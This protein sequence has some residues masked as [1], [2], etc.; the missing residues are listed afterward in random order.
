MK[1]DW[2]ARALAIGGL[3]VAFLGL[4]IAY[5]NY[6]RD[7][8]RLRLT[9]DYG[10]TRETARLFQVFVSNVGYRPMSIMRVGLSTLP[11]RKSERRLRQT[12][13]LIHHKRIRRWLAPVRFREFPPPVGLAVEASGEFPLLVQP[14]NVAEFRFTAGE[15]GCFGRSGRLGAIDRRIWASVIDVI[16]N[17]TSEPLSP[18]E[19]DAVV[20]LSQLTEETT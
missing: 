6:R 20:R 11:A 12:L 8:P 4:A 19:H 18:D 17:E 5:L 14:G 9:F 7:R 16:G 10:R 2:L 3:L 1:A 13:F 15:L